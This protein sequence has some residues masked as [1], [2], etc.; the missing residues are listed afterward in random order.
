LQDVQPECAEGPVR[1]VVTKTGGRITGLDAAVGVNWRSRSSATDLGIV[2]APDV[3]AWLIGLAPDARVDD[4]GQTVAFV[5]ANAA[6][7]ARLAV[8]LLE[9]VRNRSLGSDLR[10][11]ALRWAAEAARRE[12]RGDEAD[13]TIR[14][15]V[16][17]ETDATM[18]R[19]RA[20]RELDVTAANDAF[21]R[22]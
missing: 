2:S 5:A 9:I 16:R 18:V 17:D 1:L 8:P 7:S 12:G 3:A 20:I 10:G 11:R 14:A 13:R 15:I 19:D 4:Q 6:D 22:E 21:L